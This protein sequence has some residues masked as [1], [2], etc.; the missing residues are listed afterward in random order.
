[1]QNF[2]GLCRRDV[3]VGVSA[4]VLLFV[5]STAQAQGEFL[6]TDETGVVFP[7]EG[8]S[9]QGEV[10]IAY[11]PDVA[12]VTVQEVDFLIDGE[13]KKTVRKPPYTLLGGVKFFDTAP[14]N[15]GPHGLEALVTTDVPGDVLIV[16]A[17]FDTKNGSVPAKGL[18]VVR[19]TPDV[20]A[21]T[22]TLEGFEF[23]RGLAKGLT[24]RVSLDLFELT[25]T[26]TAST[27]L[28]ATLP[29]G[30]NVG[31]HL[32]HLST[33]GT[34]PSGLVDSDHAELLLTIGAT[35]VNCVDCV[36]AAEVDFPYA[37][38]AIEGGAATRAL[39]ADRADI[40]EHAIHADV[41][42]NAG[43]AD[44]ANLLDGFDSGEFLARGEFLI[45][46]DSRLLEGLDSNAFS[47][48][49][50][51]HPSIW[52]LNGSN[53][54]YNGG[55]VGIG[56]TTPVSTLE[57]D[58]P[59]IS[60]STSI[61]AGG[62]FTD[63]AGF[64]LGPVGGV[65]RLTTF[66]GGPSIRFLGSDDHYAN[67]AMRGL[68]LGADFGFAITS[69]PLYGMIVQGNV[70]IG[71]STP[72]TR[73]DTAGTIRATAQTVPTSGRG[74]ELGFNT[75]SNSGAIAP[76]DRDTFQYLRLRLLGSSIEM[77][78]GLPGNVGIGV[79]N[80]SQR[81]QV[82]GNILASGTV[83]AAGFVTASSREVKEDITSLSRD[84][85]FSTFERLRP[86]T[87]RYKADNHDLHVGFIAEDVPELVSVP[88]RDG[89][90]PIDLIAVLTSVVSLK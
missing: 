82:N 78:A 28:T 88:T 37:G 31:D 25:V 83:T 59:V 14:L 3:V 43:Q 22:L 17:S 65:S 60:R 72:A 8:A 90:P 18:H 85:A 58:G 89:V 47:P 6:V 66:I 10:L 75:D 12:V 67:V 41:A 56:T 55:N 61:P 1:M 74:L 79:V 11:T 29:A 39:E 77:M 32:I 57:V 49:G 16:S 69:P 84:E 68:S 33:D 42:E 38:S 54:F 20:A 53:V 23:D 64:A 15:D 35:D 40:A 86:V 4:A 46:D 81:L 5:A 73:L 44:N 70:G 7:L 52:A 9:L 45:A 71:T 2:I 87:F 51:A 21:R 13:F 63:P 26:S 34:L 27:F 48:S 50:H 24:P 80:P 19:A 62:T 30:I 76:F 36:S